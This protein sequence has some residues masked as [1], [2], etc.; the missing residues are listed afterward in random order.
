D[1]RPDYQSARKW[2]RECDSASASNGSS[3]YF[4]NSTFTGDLVQTGSIGGNFKLSSKVQKRNT[5]YGKSDNVEERAS[6]KKSSTISTD[7]SDLDY[8]RDQ[9]NA[10]GSD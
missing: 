3:V 6:K 8:P 1:P 2:K 10:S 5:N 9:T 7:E 4:H